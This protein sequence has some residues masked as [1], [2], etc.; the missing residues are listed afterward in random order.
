[1][2]KPNFEAADKYLN[3]DG[4]T[5]MFDAAGQS[6]ARDVLTY[7][8]GAEQLLNEKDEAIRR[9]KERLERNAEIRQ[10]LQNERDD[11]Q[12]RLNEVPWERLVVQSCHRAEYEAH[13]T[14]GGPQ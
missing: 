13:G 4:I 8:R 10:T 5:T 12:R 9:L 14:D 6:A 1:M 3:T 7:A 11:M 2:T